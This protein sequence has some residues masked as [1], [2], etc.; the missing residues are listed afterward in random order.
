MSDPLELEDLIGGLLTTED[1]QN[2]AEVIVDLKT[3]IV[4]QLT[5]QN[6]ILVKILSALTASSVQVSTEAKSQNA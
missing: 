2:L 6:K 1:G 5:V 4:H 3:D